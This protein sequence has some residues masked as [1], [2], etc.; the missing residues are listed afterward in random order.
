MRDCSPDALQDHVP[1]TSRDDQPGRPKPARSHRP[2]GKRP[3]LQTTGRD[4][5]RRLGSAQVGPRRRPFRSEW[6]RPME[7][8]PPVP[9]HYAGCGGRAATPM[10]TLTTPSELWWPDAC[11]GAARMRK[12]HVRGLGAGRAVGQCLPL[13]DRDRQAFAARLFRSVQRD[14]QPGQFVARIPDADAARRLKGTRARRWQ[15]A[16]AGR[17]GVDRGT[18]RTDMR[19]SGCRRSRTPHSAGGIV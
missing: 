12:R 16:A 5:R 14:A 7:P 19:V 3:W 11:Q 17:L 6:K 2:E 13:T 10:R 8:G 1:S 15:A 9:S 18:C 4:R